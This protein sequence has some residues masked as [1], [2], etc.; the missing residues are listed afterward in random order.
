MGIEDY[1][2]TFAAAVKESIFPEHKII[3]TEVME[4]A[5]ISLGERSTQFFSPKLGVFLGS[6]CKYDLLN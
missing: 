3:S 2:H 4:T 5:E 6:N 1:S